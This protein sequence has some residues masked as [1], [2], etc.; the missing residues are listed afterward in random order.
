MHRLAVL[1]VATIAALGGGVSFGGTDVEADRPSLTIE[2]VDAQPDGRTSV[3][4]SVSGLPAGTTLDVSE[5]DV[6]ENG[7]AVADVAVGDREVVGDDQVVPAVV[8]AI[9]TSGSLRGSAIAATR[10]A[11]SELATD[12][13]LSGGLIGV[14]GFASD[15]E[16]VSRLTD[17]PAAAVGPIGEL[18]ADGATRLYD[19]VARALRLAATHDGPADVIVFSDGE[20]NGSTTTLGDVQALA[21]DAEIPVTTV[22]LEGEDGFTSS[23]VDAMADTSGGRVIR[24]DAVE[25]LDGAFA[26]VSTDLRNRV[27][28]SW[29][30]PP[31][32]EREARL[33]VVATY[34]GLEDTPL[35]DGQS[36]P[37]PRLV[38]VTP[39][40]EVAG[41]GPLIAAFAT[42]TGLVVGLVMLGVA[43]A[44]LGF[45][46]LGA[47]V[48]R[49]RASRI[50]RRLSIYEEGAAPSEQDTRPRSI[51]ERVADVVDVVPRPST[52]DVRL[53]RRIEQ[54]DWPMRVGE[55][56]LLS[57]S[58]GLLFFLFVVL[59]IDAP[60]PLGLVMSVIGLALPFAA[61]EFAVRRRQRR[62]ADQLPDVLQVI[63]GA[64]R[65]GH[66][67]GTAVEG[68]VQEVA[69]PASEE[70]RR[71]SVEARL[72]RPMDEA[73]L[74][75]AARTDSEDLTWVVSALAVQREVGGNL[76]E[77]L[78]NVADTLRARAS[79][80]RQVQALSAEGR[81]SAN[82]IAAIP[83]LMFVVLTVIS[84]DYM[85]LL[86]SEPLGRVMIGIGL[87]LL[88]AG[89]IWLRRLVR[90]VY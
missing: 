12:I 60:W 55:L 31:S 2:Q 13:T 71:A 69:E 52:F 34:R 74:D 1:T 23:A 65:A 6:I 24:V 72:G 66:A 25:D 3:T 63:G 21:T 64:L 10:A 48:D 85:S 15:V 26:A 50:D 90:P 20:D 43:V 62:F 47:A 46:L 29:T 51:T 67:F 84:P 77:V 70:L 68:A 38:E 41:R 80:R 87:T 57:L 89:V 79:V 86:F 39:P 9:D 82:I 22:R 14:V 8:L 73:L 36:L 49:Q 35:T 27:T 75:V 88:V 17:D 58:F 4:L 54:A 28:L 59:T 5:F 40:R 19:G 30:A 7:E 53:A 11:A 42:T 83:F 44:L 78:G 37:N 76:A 81:L 18:E 56:L 33:N 45:V 61:L 16:T 32:T